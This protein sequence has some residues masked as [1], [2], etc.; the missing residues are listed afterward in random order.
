V[1]R[2]AGTYGEYRWGATRKE[3]MIGWEAARKEVLLPQNE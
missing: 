3:L 2:S 1:I